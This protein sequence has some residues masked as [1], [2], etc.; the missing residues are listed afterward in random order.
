MFQNFSLKKIDWFTV[1]LVVAIL[2][3]GIVALASVM[4]KPYDGTEASL[5]DYISHFNSEYLKKHIVNIALGVVALAV[6]LVIDYDLFKHFAWLMYAGIIGLLLLLFVFGAVR[7]GA[8]GWFVF[9]SLERAIQPGELS[10]IAVIVMEAKIVSKAMDEHGGLF[11][12]VDVIKALAFTAVP[13]LIIVRQS[14]YGTAIVL[15]VITVS[16]FFAARIRWYYIVGAAGAAAVGLPLVYKFILTNTQRQRIDV[17]LD[18]SAASSDA[19]YHVE[20]SKM[21]IGS[22]RLHGKGL[23]G[24]TTL[25]QLRYVPARH[26]DFIFSGITEAVGFI[27]SVVLIAAYFILMIRWIYIAMRARD[28]FGMLLVIGVVGLF[29]AHIFENIGMTMGI[30]PVTGIPLPFISYGGSNM[31]VNLIGVGI[32]LNV[33][34]RRVQRTRLRPNGR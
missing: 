13:F 7:G 30:M 18:P 4:S 10:K 24:E 1:L 6:F 33:Y 34:M 27:G 32:V 14:D 11:R 5:S 2:G 28:N 12:F 29:T 25:S 19:R 3:F 20:R 23:F 22:G 31:L 21:A 15:L 8:L 16:I 9:D 26:T 17:F